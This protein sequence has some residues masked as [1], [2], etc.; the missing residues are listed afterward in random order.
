YRASGPGGQNV[1]K[2]ETSV[3]ITHLGTGIVVSC[4][5]ERTQAGNRKKAMTMLLS[6]LYLLKQEKEQK[7]LMKAKGDKISASW[8]NQIRSYVIHPYKMIK[9]LRTGVEVSDVESVLDGDLDK[10]IIEEIKL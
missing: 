7:E 6:K 2:R 10:F 9:D 1:N 4:Q 3:R 8:G 5:A